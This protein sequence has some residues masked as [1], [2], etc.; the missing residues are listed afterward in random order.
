MA[1][2]HVLQ[3]GQ[4]HGPGQVIALGVGGPGRP[5]GLVVGAVLDTL[6]DHRHVEAAAGGGKAPEHGGG[7]AFE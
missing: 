2:G 7:A 4:R 5:G 6:N 3:F 1:H